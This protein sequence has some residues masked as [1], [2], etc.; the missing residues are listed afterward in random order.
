[1]V[2]SLTFPSLPV[3]SKEGDKFTVTVTEYILIACLGVFAIVL[4]VLI[5]LAVQ[6]ARLNKSVKTLKM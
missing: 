1:M 4:I 6:I 3:D 2:S 5:I